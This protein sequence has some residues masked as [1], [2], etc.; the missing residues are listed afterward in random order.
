MPGAINRNESFFASLQMQPGQRR[1]SIGIQ[2]Q[3]AIA[4]LISDPLSRSHVMIDALWQGLIET[5]NFYLSFQL[6]N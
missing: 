4:N 1:F 3:K 6:K 5:R 2:S